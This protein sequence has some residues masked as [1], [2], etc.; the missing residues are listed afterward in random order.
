MEVIIDSSD[1]AD[2][3]ALSEE[4]VSPLEKFK[5]AKWIL[6]GCALIFFASGYAAIF[7]P[8]GVPIFDAC[9]TILPSIVTLVIGYYFG[10]SSRRN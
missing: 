1:V 8:T 7:Y 9:K 5:F 10:E 6:L 4:N 2:T 3:P